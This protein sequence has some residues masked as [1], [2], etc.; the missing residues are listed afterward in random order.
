[1][2]L[3]TGTDVGKTYVAT[4]LAQL[5]ASARPTDVVI[6]VKPLESG[7]VTL[8]STDAAALANASHPPIEPEHALA[9]KRPISPHL[10]ARLE[11]KQ[12]HSAD[13]ANWA[14][15]RLVNTSK[16]SAP[17]AHTWL[18]VETAGGVFSPLNERECNLTLARALEPALWLLVAPDRLGVIHDLVATQQTMEQ[19][20]RK[21]NL[22]VLNA[23]SQ[24]DASTGTNASELEHLGIA[25]V[26]AQLGRGVGFAADDSARLIQKLLL[27]DPAQ[28]PALT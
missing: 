2:I 25:T 28:P 9:L 6:A 5:I 8:Q 17:G 24:P 16:A 22:L 10:A 15:G 12:V 18:I 14:R 1:M 20:A 11:G 27:S 23:P 21:P 7:V 26:T 13:L 4:A 19:Q 3:G